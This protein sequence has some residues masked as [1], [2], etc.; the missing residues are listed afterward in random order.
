[1]ENFKFKTMKKYIYLFVLLCLS[2]LSCKD[3]D[4]EMKISLAQQNIHIDKFINYAVKNFEE[5]VKT[6]EDCDSKIPIMGDS[7][8]VVNNFFNTKQP[9]EITFLI[10]LGEGTQNCGRILNQIYTFDRKPRYG[11]EFYK[12]LQKGV[13]DYEI[14]WKNKVEIVRI[15]YAVKEISFE[16]EGKKYTKVAMFGNHNK[17]DLFDFNAMFFYE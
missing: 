2:F 14:L 17:K 9:Y 6:K 13:L 16:M 4:K 1:M 11:H 7:S 12:T 5:R 8:F 15:G 10:S 3:T